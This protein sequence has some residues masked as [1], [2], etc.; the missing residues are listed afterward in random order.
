MSDNVNLAIGGAIIVLTACAGLAGVWVGDT[1]NVVGIVVLNASVI[2]V[3]F[4]TAALG[5]QIPSSK[6]RH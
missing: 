6:Y 4:L 1:G 5:I 2:G 3:G